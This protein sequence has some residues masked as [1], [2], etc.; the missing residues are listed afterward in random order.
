[1][2]NLTKRNFPRTLS[3]WF[4]NDFYNDFWGDWIDNMQSKTALR[5]EFVPALNV[6]EM[7]NSVIV[8][9]ELPG[10]NKE[11]VEVFLDHGM[12]TIKGEKK[13]EQEH[14]DSKRSYYESSFGSFTRTVRLPYE[15]DKERV[16]A[17]FNNGVLKIEL[18]KSDEMKKKSRRINID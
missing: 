9:A 1:M 2:S 16:K 6:N 10:M 13:K 15:I 14:S 18:A 5:N 17:D 7:E 3:N 11:N 12:L 4:D 8:E